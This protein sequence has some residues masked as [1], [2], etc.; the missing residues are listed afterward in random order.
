MGTAGRQRPDRMP[1]DMPDRT[2]D[3]M[4]D[5][6]P[7]DMPDRMPED[8]PDRMPEG[9]PDRMSDRMPENLPDR[10]PEDLPDNM[11]EDMPDRMPEDM[12]EHMPEDMPDRVPEDMPQHMPEDMPGRMPEDMP[13]R[14]P[15]D[16]PDKMPED[17]PVTERINVMVGMTRSKVIKCNFCCCAFFEFHTTYISLLNGIHPYI[18]TYMYALYIYTCKS[19]VQKNQHLYMHSPSSC[20]SP[21]NRCI[22]FFRRF[23]TKSVLL[24]VL[25][26]E[27]PCKNVSL[28]VSY[29]KGRTMVC[30]WLYNG[31]PGSS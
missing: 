15:E 25:L 10:M 14:M 27:C 8:M 18:H 9:M 13:D 26:E 31:L 16:L 11:R 4:S 12:P 19:H 30:S 22:W 6:M 1:E 5:R 29:Q 3:R 24:R 17:M 23:L 20:I 21:A 2:P 7:E 28:R